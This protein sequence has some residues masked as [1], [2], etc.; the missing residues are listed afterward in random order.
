MKRIICAAL[1][2]ISM[3]I[4]LGAQN[5]FKARYDRLVARGGAAGLGVETLLDSWG[6]ADSLSIDYLKARSDFYY[7]KS[8]STEVVVKPTKKYLGCDPIFELKDSTGTPQYY[9]QETMYDE[10]TIGESL[11]WIGF[12]IEN[13][14]TRLD[15]RIDRITTLVGYEKESP[16]M[17]TTELMRLIDDHFR[18]RVVWDLPG[19]D[20]V[21][22]GYFA[23]IIQEYCYTFYS[24]A[25]VSSQEAFRKI[26]EKM[27]SLC[28]KETM[29]IDNLGSYYTVSKDYKTALKYYGKSLK[30]KPDDLTAIRNSVVITTR[31]KDNKNLRKYLQMLEKYGNENEKIQAKVRLEALK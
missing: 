29:F 11:R 19:A 27:N 12:A 24:I 31:Q 9:Y 16:D 28:P 3:S 1:V 17:A 26:S 22:D 7:V 21:D 6:A 2:A 25:S 5:D 20:K 30:I 15:L 8:M 4:S 13:Y 23:D 10:R 18:K 14:P